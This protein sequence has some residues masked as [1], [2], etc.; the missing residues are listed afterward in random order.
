[1][2]RERPEE[3]DWSEAHIVM[4]KLDGSMIHPCL[5]GGEMVF[6]TRMGVTDQAKAALGNADDA[7]RSLCME[8][9]KDGITPIFEYTSPDNRIVVPYEKTA[10]TL[11]AL[12]DIKSGAYVAHDALVAEATSYGVPVVDTFGEV[13]DGKSFVETS[14][15]LENIEGYVIAFDS[16]HRLKLKADHYVLRHKALSGVAYEKNLLAW[17]AENA[18]DDVLP[19]LP[20]EVAVRVRDYEAQIKTMSNR[21]LRDIEAL[22]STMK[23]AERKEIAMEV[24]SRVDPRL[25]RI[26]FAIL[27]G[28]DG[29]SVM[30]DIIRKASQSEPKVDE[31]RDLWDMEWFGRDLVI[32]DD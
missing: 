17:I 23:G 1:G 7:V 13:S 20:D 22:L 4:D 24:R 3:I 14:R 8:S 12:R 16:G 19:I 2:E 18:L 26:A 28:R 15:A 29:H 32:K 11:L 30:L 10:L 31:F 5:V 9:L 27:D 6:M 21:H 25:Q